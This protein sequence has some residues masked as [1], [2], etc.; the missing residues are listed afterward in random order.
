MEKQIEREELTTISLRIPKRW[1]EFFREYAI[2]IGYEDNPDEGVSKI[3]HELV[4]DD[5]HGLLDRMVEVAPLKVKKLK[6]RYNL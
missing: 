4:Q 5:I 1:L 2:W 3:L 6:K